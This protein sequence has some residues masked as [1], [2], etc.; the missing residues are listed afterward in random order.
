VNITGGV[1]T[2]GKPGQYFADLSQF[3]TAAAADRATNAC[4]NLYAT[5]T[6]YSG[7]GG[8]P[9]VGTSRRNPYSGPAFISQ[10]FAIQKRT[11]LYADH[12]ALI[13]RAEFFNLFDRANYYNPIT[14]FS[15]DGVHLNPEFGII[16]S[17]HDPRQIQL[18]IRFDF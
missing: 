16:R 11:R 17:A 10:D 4:P 12:G 7:S 18:A 5:P 9:C 13:L 3:T 2:T 15:T 1:H 6:L 14:E 8:Q